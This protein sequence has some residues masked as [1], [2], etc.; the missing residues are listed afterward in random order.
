MFDPEGVYGPFPVRARPESTLARAERKRGISV[1]SLPYPTLV[2]TGDDFREERGAVAAHYA[3]E[4]LD[5]G[6]RNHWELVLGKETVRRI[7]LWA[8][9]STGITTDSA[10]PT[11]SARSAAIRSE[12]S[13][14][15]NG[16]SRSS[17]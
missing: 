1:P 4:Q 8:G 11:R 14:P 5:L 15:R 17:G 16:G 6:G 3:A 2:V 7:V 9:C 13:T 10:R 12:R